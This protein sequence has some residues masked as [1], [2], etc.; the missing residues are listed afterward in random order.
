MRYT[1]RG[2]WTCFTLH[3]GRCCFARCPSRSL[4]SSS[5]TPPPTP[6]PPRSQ[7]C[8]SMAA[9]QHCSRVSSLVSSLGCSR[10]RPTRW[11][12]AS[13]M[14]ARAAKRRTCWTRRGAR[15][16]TT[17]R[18]SS[19]ALRHAAS[20]LAPPSAGSTCCTISGRASS[21][22]PPTTSTW[23]STSSPTASPSTPHSPRH[24][25]AS[26]CAARRS[27]AA[28]A[29]KSCTAAMMHVVDLRRAGQ[30]GRRQARLTGRIR[31]L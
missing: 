28:C 17:L 31:M 14:R 13:Q 3:Y 6:S 11:S 26:T 23:C 7:R 16:P 4:N 1:P 22:Y 29:C 2:A 18:R 10:R 12:R 30:S 21:A 5:S 25:E 8:R 19:R 15:L 27:E 9:R 24:V 20:S